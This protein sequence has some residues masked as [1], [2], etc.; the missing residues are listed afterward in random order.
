M[1]PSLANHF[2]LQH[3]FVLSSNVSFSGLAESILVMV[4]HPR[5]SASDEFHSVH[6]VLKFFDVELF[7]STTICGAYRPYYSSTT[8]LLSKGAEQNR[9]EKT[10]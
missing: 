10:S 6:R 2:L 9:W 5:T 1:M 3:P 8:A 4:E 7:L